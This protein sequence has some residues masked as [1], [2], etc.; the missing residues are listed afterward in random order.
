MET[1]Y[2]GD[3]MCDLILLRHG[4]T[5]GQSSIRFF[6]LTDIPLSEIGIIQM[7]RAGEILKKHVFNTVIASPLRR[8]R[9][10]AAIVLDGRHHGIL[11]IDN[12]R[13]IN[14][15][16]WEGLTRDEIARRDPDTYSALQQSGANGGFPGGDS[17][18]EFFSRVR[19]A[20]L[21]IF[22]RAETPILAVLHKGVIRGII[23]GLLGKQP[24]DISNLPIELG[25]IHRLSKSPDGWRLIAA[26]ETGHLGEYRMENT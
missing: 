24:E 3:T 9:D 2:F 4:E 25:S 12:F 14:F 15:G 13:E 23:S 18:P 5:A 16:A 6:G 17:K 8:S 20:A 22:N 11:V 26:N 19:K 1:V 10:S 7:R 21:D